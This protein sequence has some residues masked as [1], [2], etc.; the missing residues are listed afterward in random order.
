MAETS[1]TPG[2]GLRHWMRA[3]RHGIGAALRSMRDEERRRV[4]ASGSAAATRRRRDRQRRSRRDGDIGA[5]FGRQGRPSASLVAAGTGIVGREEA[6]RAVAV[7]HLAQIGRAREDVVARV[8]GI[9]AEMATRKPAQVSGMI[10]IRPIAP[11]GE[12]ARGSPRLS[13][14]CAYPRLGT[15]KRCAASAMIA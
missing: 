12:I 11:L 2:V 5:G 14:A 8:V 3:G 4:Q 13:R 9:G 15:P 6:G 1:R 7:V 10:C